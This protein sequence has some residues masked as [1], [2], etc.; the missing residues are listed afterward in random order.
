M[1]FQF[2]DADK[3][4]IIDSRDLFY[5]Y[6]KLNAEIPEEKVKET[7]FED[8]KSRRKKCREFL[9]K[10]I[11]WLNSIILERR[12]KEEKLGLKTADFKDKEE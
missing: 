1:V 10:E 4:G 9:I 7:G 3:N 2:W 8:K 12:K 11:N 5:V 6:E